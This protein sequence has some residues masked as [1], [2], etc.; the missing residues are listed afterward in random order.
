[1]MTRTIREINMNDNN[2]IEY[3]FKTYLY[4]IIVALLLFSRLFSHK[5]KSNSNSKRKKIEISYMTVNGNAMVRFDSDSAPIKI[6]NCATRSMSNEELDFISS[7]MVEVNDKCVHSYGGAT[8]P[9]TKVGTISWWILDDTGI[10]RNIQVPNSYFVPG[11]TSKLLSPQHWAQQSRETGRNK[12]EITCTTTAD[13]VILQ[14]DQYTKTINLDQNG[15]NV[16]T[17]W[18]VPGYEQA[19]QA[20]TSAVANVGT[21]M[22]FDTEVIEEVVQEQYPT[23]TTEE[24]LPIEI[25]DTPQQVHLETEGDLPNGESTVRFTVNYDEDAVQED[26]TMEGEEERNQALLIS[27]H[28]KMGHV[29]MHRLQYMASKGLL[30]RKIAKCRVPLCQSCIYG[31]MAR[32]AWRAKGEVSNILRNITKP[33]QHVSVDQLESPTPGLI[34]QI[35]GTPT[36]ARYRVATIFVDGYSRASYVFLQQTTNAEETLEAKRQYESFARSYGVT[37]QHYHADNGRFMENVWRE[38]IR[39]QGQTISYSGVGAHHQNG[40]VEK[41]IRDL[42]DLTRTCLIYASSKWPEAINVHLWPYALLKANAVLN[43]TLSGKNEQSAVE[44]FANVQVVP[45]HSYEHPFGCPAY[46][47]DG[48]LQSGAKAKKWD[49][50]GRLG[51]YLGQSQQYSRKVSLILSLSTG[52]VSPQ[53]HVVHDD[54]FY[55]L[56]KY[57]RNTIPTSM[58]QVKCAFVDSGTSASTQNKY[59]SVELNRVEREVLVNEDIPVLESRRGDVTGS[60]E[61]EVNIPEGAA[62][63]GT[64][65]GDAVRVPQV[66]NVPEP[67]VEPITTTRSGREVRAPVHLQDYVVYETTTD[68]LQVHP[69]SDYIH[70]THYSE[71]RDDDVTFAASTDPDTLY[72]H[73]AMREPD[74]ANFLAAMQD[75]VQAQTDNKNWEVVPRG[76]LPTGTRVLPAVWA[77]KRKRKVLCGT[78][79]KWKARLNVDGAKQVHGLDYWETYAPVASWSTIRLVLTIAVRNKWTIRQVDF[80]QAF[81]QAPIEAELYMEIPKGFNV[82]GTRD[83][84]ALRLLRNV[85]GQKQAGRVWNDYLVKGLQELGFRQSKNDMCLLWR[86]TTILVIYTD[87]TLIVGP[88]LEEVEKAIMDIGTS[89]DITHSDKVEDFLGVNIIIDDDNNTI[90]YTQPQLIKSILKDLGLNDDSKQKEVPAVAGTVL[91]EHKS[92]DNHCENWDYRSVVGKLNYLE[93]SSRPDLAFAVHQCARFT[94]N[95]KVEHSA[96]IKHI[97]RYLVATRDKGIICSPNNTSI[98]CYSDASFAGE[99]V[100]ENAE[101]DPTT[102]RSRTGYIIMYGNCPVVW[103][104]K[105][106]SEIALSATEAEYIALSQSLREVT[107]LFAILEELKQ[108]IPG[109]NVELPRVHCTAFEDNSGAIEMARCPKMR[110]R[111]KHLNIKYHHF[112]QA[113]AEEKIEIRYIRSGLQIA[114]L[115]TKALTATLFIKLRTMI[116]GWFTTLSRFAQRECDDKTRR[117]STETNGKESKRLKRK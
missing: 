89:F 33:G 56:R 84:H 26:S 76:A 67:S 1:M 105:L 36:H 43:N 74:R 38:D 107:S 81:P 37:V 16:A 19:Y 64:P 11:G 99:W 82:G 110:P 12:M 62:T 106:Q 21:S 71:Y 115:L 15:N 29:S 27:W 69:E 53:F 77:M 79:Y 57:A 17:M 60:N 51:I 68:V 98:H 109:L 32:K 111:T 114:D 6:D 73:E 88:L 55:T 86:V 91:Q 31:M 113:V 83:T 102:A 75:E 78:V 66:A 90:N 104:S 52:L 103:A 48:P 44:K 100:K 18:T 96:A 50:R 23:G 61:R 7:T 2:N 97:G 72:L 35:K 46:V 10:K 25:P 108:A 34:G 8:I 63:A 13:S 40:L 116:M 42:Q 87:D 5:G 9:I 3:Y 95:P 80:V 49:I 93:K 94:R 28:Y 41:R 59:G 4:I 30:P 65:A 20:I 24:G 112:R 92:S 117:T 101:H 22:T 14:W 45:N 70:P 58:W 54:E 39:R 85:Y 47:L